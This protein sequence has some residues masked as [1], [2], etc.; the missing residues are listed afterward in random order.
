[1]PVGGLLEGIPTTQNQVFLKG[2][3]IDGSANGEPLAGKPT[4]RGEAA[5]VKHIANGGIAEIL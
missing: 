1:M 3:V 5:Q 2:F 4:G